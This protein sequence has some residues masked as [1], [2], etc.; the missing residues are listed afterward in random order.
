MQCKGK[1]YA[2]LTIL[3][4]IA[5]LKPVSAS[6]KDGTDTKVRDGSFYFSWG[7]NKDWFSQSDIH[8]R[9]PKSGAYDFTL[10]DLKAKDR[11]GFNQ[12][13]TSDIS[14]PQYVYRIG[15]YS[16]K[17]KLGIEI[18]FDHTKYVVIQD[19]VAHIKGRINETYYDQDTVISADF[20]KFEHTNGA[21]FLLLNVTKRLKIHS[22]KNEKFRS[23]WV[24]KGG[25]GIV[26]P[27]TDVTLFG[28][29]LDNK[30][31]VAGFI[32]GVETGLRLELMRHLFIEA[33]MKGSYANYLNVLTVS[34]GKA[35][36]HFWTAETILTGG[37]QF[38]F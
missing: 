25:A 14:I 22:T 34:D 27:K 1:L 36:H 37:Y 29:R 10:Y 8:F 33:T 11:P 21:N 24:V 26:I 18:N 2:G 6:D 31:H 9:N 7:Y 23:L 17:H 28:E 4:L 32:F 35:K 5:A 12:I 16:Q 38:H 15:Y 19:Q 3:I 20:L 13:V 30:F